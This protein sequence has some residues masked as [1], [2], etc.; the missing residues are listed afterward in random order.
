MRFYIPYSLSTWSGNCLNVLLDE[1][2]MG[3]MLT[4]ETIIKCANIM[5]T[6]F[7]VVLAGGSAAFNQIVAR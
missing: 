7:A 5:Q 6:L 2:A 1:V 4:S 3:G